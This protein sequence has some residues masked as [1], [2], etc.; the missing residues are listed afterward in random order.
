MGEMVRIRYAKGET[1]WAEDL[2]G[3]QYRID[4]IPL[5]RSR[6]RGNPAG[7]VADTTPKSNNAVG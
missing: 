4:N 7:I 5:N 1:G 3:G 2:G 6:D